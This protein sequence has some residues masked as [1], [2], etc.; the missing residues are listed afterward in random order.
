MTIGESKIKVEIASIGYCQRTR[1]IAGK[2]G[3]KEQRTKPTCID[4]QNVFQMIIYLYWH[5]R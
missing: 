5:F 2:K 3:H 4:N 1:R